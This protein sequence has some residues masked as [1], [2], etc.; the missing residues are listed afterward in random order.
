[1]RSRGSI[2]DA[3]SRWAAR[4]SCMHWP[5]VALRGHRRPVRSARGRVSV[6]Y[7]TSR[8]RLSARKNVAMIPRTGI[9]QAITRSA[10]SWSGCRATDFRCDNV[11]RCDRPGGNR[12]IGYPG[13]WLGHTGT[14]ICRRRGGRRSGGLPGFAR[15]FVEQA[16]APVASV[17]E[18]ARFQ[19]EAVDLPP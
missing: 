15:P 10:V 8:I 2:S 19:A 1:M 17:A 13:G 5:D 9:F 11:V 16:D 6:W 12:T 7:E 14:N 4:F 3:I 18:L